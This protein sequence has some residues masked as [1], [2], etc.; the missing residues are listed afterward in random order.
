MRKLRH[1][2]RVLTG[3]ILAAF[4]TILLLVAATGIPQ[5]D[6]KKDT[7]PPFN[8]NIDDPAE[9]GKAF[10]KHYELYKKSDRVRTGTQGTRTADVR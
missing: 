2:P 4:G 5:S 1:P 6:A 7:R 3:T 8:D 10:P 9:W